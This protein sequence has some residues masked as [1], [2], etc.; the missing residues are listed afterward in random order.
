MSEP[1]EITPEMIA[2]YQKRQQAEKQAD[3]QNVIDG[4]NEF[5]AKRGYIIAGIIQQVPDGRSGVVAIGA[6]W[7]IQDK[8]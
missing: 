6:T 1:V 5:A 8:S 2:E 3:M 4:L 7:G